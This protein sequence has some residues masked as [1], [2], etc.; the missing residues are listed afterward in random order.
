MPIMDGLTATK[1]ILISSVYEIFPIIAMDGPLSED[2]KKAV[3]QQYEW[4]INKAN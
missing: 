4:R 1:N 2:A 3:C